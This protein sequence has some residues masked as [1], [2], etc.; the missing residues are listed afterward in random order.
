MNDGLTL[1]ERIDDVFM[2]LLDARE[3]VKAAQAN[4]KRLQ[5]HYETLCKQQEEEDE[6]AISAG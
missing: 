2:Q 3:A 6:N 5:R 4:V 1:S